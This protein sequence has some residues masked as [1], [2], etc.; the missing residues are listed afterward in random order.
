MAEPP[1][2]RGPRQTDSWF[3]G[4]GNLP[5]ISLDEVPGPPGAR[6]DSVAELPDSAAPPACVEPRR[7]ASAAFAAV[8]TAGCVVLSAAGL[9]YARLKGIPLWAAG[10]LLAAFLAEFPFYLVPAFPDLRDRIAP[11]RLPAYLVLSALLPY[12]LCCVGPCEFQWMALARMAALAL[13][14][15]LWFVVLP[16]WWIVDLAFLALLAAVLLGH[17]FDAVFVPL[18]PGLQHEM[19]FLGHFILIQLGIVV[20]ML[21]RRVPETGYGFLPTAREW[22]IG[23]LHYLYFAAA[24]LPLAWLLRAIELRRHPVPFWSIAGTF[25]GFLWV[26]A[27][28]EEFLFRGVLQQWIEGWLSS[29]A[30]ALLAA[31]AAFGAIHLWFTSFPFP[32]WRWA[33]IATVLGFCCGHARNQA[34]GIR[35]GMVTHALAVATWRAFFA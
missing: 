16:R 32:N 8:L 20:L 29:R 17:F 7:S 4:A 27:L 6:L 24:A 34:G 22:R 28:S 5:E 3:A 30:A 9:L 14:L 21:A 15:G 10:P 1:Q 13:A 18:Y 2:D 33:L 11:R 23:I 31:S 19:A 35:A 25:L 26:I 12:L